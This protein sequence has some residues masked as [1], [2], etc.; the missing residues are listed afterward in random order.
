MRVP[1]R[2]AL[3]S[4]LVFAAFS[5]PLLAED[6]SDGS[7]DRLDDAWAE[8]ALANPELDRG[9][10]QSFRDGWSNGRVGHCEVREFSYPRATEPVAINGG[11]NG[12]MT[13]MGWDRDSVRILYRVIARARTE[14]RARALAAEIQLE[15]TKGWLRPD[16]PTEGSRNEWWTVEV[17]AWVPHASDLALRVHN[18]PLGVRD[19]RGTMILDA[20]NGPVS[21]VDLS[22]AV[23]ARVQ[24]GPL[25]VALAGARWD[26]AGLDAEAQNGPL[27]LALP[28]DYSARLTTGTI[29]GPRS[30]DYAIESG[31]SRAWI[32]T[33]LGKG[34]PPVRVVTNNGPFHITER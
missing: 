34:G 2:L 16:G 12:G 5:S 24:N 17:K 31:R 9:W 26:G 10:S 7:S 15:L 23:E 11:H 6:D 30:F 22:G 21:L 3:S 4:F 29:H 20:I 14:E 33:T 32:T 27:T 8:R 13:V 18:G 19:V 25:Y 28:A 1:F